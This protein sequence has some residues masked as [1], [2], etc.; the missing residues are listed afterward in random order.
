MHEKAIG[1]LEDRILDLM[2]ESEPLDLNV[3][4]AD[5]ALKAEKAQVE[6]ETKQARAR[7]AEDEKAS[8]DFHRERA[9]IVSAVT[10]AV[11]QRY[12][13]VRKARKGIG[14]AEAVDG[15]CSACNMAMRPQFFQDLKRG[16][17]VM[18]CESCLRILYYNPPVAVEHQAGLYRQR[19]K[20]D[21][22]QGPDQGGGRHPAAGAGRYH[23]CAGAPDLIPRA[24]PCHIGTRFSAVRA[25]RRGEWP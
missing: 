3:K 4:A 16:A 7:T 11:Y 17:E 13:R 19:G 8:R 24:H 5:V 1:K 14:I 25:G 23:L 2:G 10:P 18:S 12:E 21:P 20:P 9:E 15:R 6:A 22:R